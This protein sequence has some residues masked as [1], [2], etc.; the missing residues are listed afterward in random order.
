[1]RLPWLVILCALSLAGEPREEVRTLP[2]I[3]LEGTPYQ[4]G[5]THGTRW[6]EEIQRAVDVWKSDLAATYKMDAGAFIHEFAAKTDYLPAIRKWTPGLLDEVRGIAEGSGMDFETMLV[7]QLIDEYWVNGQAVASGEHCS[8]LG[9]A[10]TNQHAAIIAQNM[11]L[12]GFRDGHQAVLHIKNESGVE[13]LVLT[14]PGLIAL[15]GM[16]NRGVA[17]TT[18]TLSQLAHARNGLPVAFVV[19]GILERTRY[20]G[21]TA[22]V[23]GVSHA[24]GQNYIVAS[25]VAV[26]DFE[27]SSGQVVALPRQSAFV[28]HTNHPIANHDYAEQYRRAGVPKDPSDNTHMR[29]AAL[30]ARLATDAG[31]NVIRQVKA[32]LESHDSELHPICRRFLSASKVCTF[33]SVVMVLGEQPYLLVA[34]GAPDLYPYQRLDFS[35][36]A[37]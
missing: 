37:K 32:T 21:A 30:E 22:F 8:A 31:Q 16:N 7:Y 5:L 25:P 3:T 11:D 28:Y 18:N 26:V 27:A 17:V 2:L 13:A 23:R 19:R 10:A 15:N 34:P 33:A 9:I 20:E 35:Q 29:Y 12:E 14:E 1:M 24:S 4:R 6:R 36:L